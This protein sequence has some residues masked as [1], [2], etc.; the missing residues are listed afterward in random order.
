MVG[1]VIFTEISCGFYF[2]E[3]GK[4]RA[5]EVIIE[6]ELPG[7]QQTEEITVAKRCEFSSLNL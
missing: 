6:G 3:V 7:L 1:P 2:T 5:N 4:G